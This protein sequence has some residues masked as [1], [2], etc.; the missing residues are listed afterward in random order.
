MATPERAVWPLPPRPPVLPTPDPIPR[1]MRTRD[2]REPCLSLISLS[3]IAVYPSGLLGRL[4]GA[5]VE[6]AHEMR[7]LVDHAAHGGSVLQLARAM[8]LVESE[9]AQR[10]GLD[11]RAARGRLDLLNLQRLLLVSHHTCFPGSAP[12]SRVSGGIAGR[13]SVAAARDDLAHLL[14]AARSHAARVLLALQ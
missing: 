4:P 5:V 11:L 13:R 3:C 12:R 10:L 1:P 2:L 6:D 8:E 9:P 14:V 7:N